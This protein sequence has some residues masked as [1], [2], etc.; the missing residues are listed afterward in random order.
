MPFFLK[1]HAIN[2]NAML[3]EFADSLRKRI[4]NEG[5]SCWRCDVIVD[6]YFKNNLKH[7]IWSSR[8]LGCRKH[9]NDETKISGDFRSDFLTNN[10]NKNDLQVYLAGK[11]VETPIFQKH[12]VIRYSDSILTNIENIIAEDEIS[13]CDIE[14]AHQ[15][16]ISHLINCAKHGFK[17]CLFHQVI[18]TC[19]FYWCQFCQIFMKIMPIRNCWQFK[20]LQS[21]WLMF[22]LDKWCLHSSSLFSC[23]Y[24]VWH[25]VNFLQSQ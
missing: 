4:L 20:I 22:I 21:E 15:K 24:R 3:L 23:F 17:N 13:N 6:L 8:G 7:N 14:E 10:D 5:S 12:V 16:T 2:K 19:W 11:F 25:D 1:S 18:L 9:F